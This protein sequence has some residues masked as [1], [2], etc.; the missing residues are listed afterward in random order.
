MQFVDQA[1]EEIW[2]AMCEK[3]ANAGVHVSGKL[4]NRGDHQ[5]MDRSLLLRQA[6]CA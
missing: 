2:K 4:N 6:R 1:F 3:T 5:S